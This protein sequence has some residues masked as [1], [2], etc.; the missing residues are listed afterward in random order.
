MQI[1]TSLTVSMLAGDPSHPSLSFTGMGKKPRTATNSTVPHCAR[2]VIPAWLG[3]L[4]GC[5][6][7]CQ[8]TDCL[9]L[10]IFGCVFGFHMTASKKKHMTAIIPCV[11]KLILMSTSRMKSTQREQK[12]N[13]Y[14]EHM[15][16]T[17]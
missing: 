16:G 13:I 17:S 3:A 12:R 10:T 1:P 2:P 4:I 9:L 8:T 5:T 7:G 6:A 15:H 14:A 11:W